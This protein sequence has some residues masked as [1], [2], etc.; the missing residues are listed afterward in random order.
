MSNPK[1][2][3]LLHFSHFTSLSKEEETSIIE[4]LR[5]RTFSAG[6]L[7]LQE[8]QPDQMTFFVVS[9]LV[10]RYHLFNGEEVTTAFYTE[11][12]WIISVGQTDTA[13]LSPDFL[14]C[15][16]PGE[17]ILG[18]ES[19]AQQLFQKHPRFETISRAI[20]EK[21]FTEQM[22]QLRLYR[23]ESPENRYLHLQKS[24]PDLFQRLPQYLI[25]GYLGIK[26][27]SLSRIRKR[28]INTKP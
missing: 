1:H 18:D 8:G 3:L 16:E 23:T 22:E 4:S 28:L 7:L 19:S 25:A 14:E 12:Q 10:R 17:L 20:L 11:G 24:R 27:E 5:T 15:L 26:P 13:R 6:E 9:G 21:A 2:P